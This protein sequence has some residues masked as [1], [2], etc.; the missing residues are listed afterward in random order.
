MNQTVHKIYEYEKECTVA[1]GIM[2]HHWK[3]SEE[4]LEEAATDFFEMYEAMKDNQIGG[5][6]AYVV[7][8]EITRFKNGYGH[9]KVNITDVDG[10][11]KFV[12]YDDEES[13]VLTLKE[14]EII[15]STSILG[16]AGYLLSKY[17]NLKRVT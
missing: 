7:G 10:E 3:R 15:D 5:T 13:D 4:N 6:V 11:R 2:E 8:E 9:F 1:L 12:K 14:L 16:K 17:F